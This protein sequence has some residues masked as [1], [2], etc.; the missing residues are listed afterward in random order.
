MSRLATRIGKLALGTEL[1]DPMSGFFVLSRTTLMAALP[2]MSE[3][4]FKFYSILLL[5]RYRP[6]QKLL[7][8]PI[9]SA[10]A[11]RAKARQALWLRQNIWR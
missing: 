5:P 7:K 4:G 9:T 2:R 3:V 11:K 1:S 8:Y 6:R 10:A